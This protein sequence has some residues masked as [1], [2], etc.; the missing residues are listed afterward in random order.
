LIADPVPAP[1]PSLIASHFEDGYRKIIIF[2]QIFFCLLLSV[3]TFT[4]VQVIKKSQN[5]RNQGFS[6][7]FSLLMEGS[8]SVQIITDIEY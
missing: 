7:F 3:G 2:L 6:Y 8:G 1:D 4:S 5:S